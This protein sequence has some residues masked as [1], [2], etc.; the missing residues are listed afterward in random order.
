MEN[1]P[2]LMCGC[3]ILVSF[4]IVLA[5][6]RVKAQYTRRALYT[7]GCKDSLRSLVLSANNLIKV[8]EP[9]SSF[10]VWIEFGVP[11][12]SLKIV[13]PMRQPRRRPNNHYLVYCT[14]GVLFRDGANELLAFH[15]TVETILNTPYHKEPNCTWISSP[16]QYN[17]SLVQ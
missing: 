2:G 4:V 6:D 10:P 3:L 15:V 17:S 14:N 16:F 12:D 1:T 5:E 9:C 13:S 11:A 8:K 7:K